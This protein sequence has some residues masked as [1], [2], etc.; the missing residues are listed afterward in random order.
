VRASRAKI[1]NIQVFLKE[2]LFNNSLPFK[3]LGK[4]REMQ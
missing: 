2:A 4:F 1:Q 3:K